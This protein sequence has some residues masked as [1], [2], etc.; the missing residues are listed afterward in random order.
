MLAGYASDRGDLRRAIS[1][2]QRSG[3]DLEDGA[4]PFHERLQVSFDRV[5]RNDPCP[6]GSGRKFKQCHL[7]K[8]VIPE[9]KRMAW[10][11]N[12]LVRYMN[13]HHRHDAGAIINGPTTKPLPPVQI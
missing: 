12:K 1:L 5:G 6:C 10:K 8:P 13:A 9:H 11:F 7:D 3:E 2:W 4:I